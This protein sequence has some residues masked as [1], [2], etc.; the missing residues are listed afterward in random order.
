MGAAELDEPER[1]GEARLSW[2]VR[3]RLRGFVSDEV[4]ERL[5]GVE[6]PGVEELVSG[7]VIWEAW[8]AL[9]ESRS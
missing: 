4:A 3:S 2:R 5:V 7:R 8:I 1:A 6:L 9:G